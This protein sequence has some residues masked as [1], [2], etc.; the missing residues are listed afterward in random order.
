VEESLKEKKKEELKKT[1]L[2]ALEANAGLWENTLH[3]RP[4]KKKKS[5]RTKPKH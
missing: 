4:G 5:Q 2:R 1:P 3:R